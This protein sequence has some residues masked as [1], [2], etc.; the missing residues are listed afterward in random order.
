MSTKWNPPFDEAFDLLIDG[1]RVPAASG[2]T[3]SVRDPRTQEAFG[4]VAA[5]GPDD[6]DAAVAAAREGQTEWQSISNRK[7]GRILRDVAEL[8]RDHSDRLLELLLLENGKSRPHAEGEV[9]VAAKYFDYYAGI[10]DKIQG[11]QIP[12]GDEYVDFTVREPLGVI[13]QIVPWNL[14]VQLF[15][16]GSAVSLATGNAVV[17]KPAEQTP[18]TA[19]AIGELIH[20]A[21]VPAKAFNVVP[22]FGHEAG[23]ALTEHE[24]VDGLA[25]TG[26]VE[27]G[28]KVLQEAGKRLIPAHGELGGKSPNAVFP[29]AD[30]DHAVEQAAGAIFTA[31]AGQACSAGS[32]L[33]VHSDI[34]DEFVADVADVAESIAVGPDV[35][36]PDIS[37]II[38]ERQ[39]ENVMDYI[40]IGREE[41]G[42]PLVGG[43]GYQNGGY[44]VEPTIFADVDNG[45]RIAQE[46]IFGPVLVTIS[47]DDEAEAIR[48]ANDTNY[49]LAAGIFTSDI[50]RAHRY[51]REVDAGQIYINQYFAEDISTPF[52][53]YKQSGRGREKGLEAIHEYTQVKNVCAN[54]TY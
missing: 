45:T 17:A 5:G 43:E 16:R 23:A 35:D 24:G 14:P 49:G 51:A 32:R 54:I 19:L 25:F 44:Y 3:L 36:D 48:I 47:F 39:F 6:V 9:E 38:S 13:G 26:S 29:D 8:I 15:G 22:G 34:H 7:R 46:E 52:G 42:D 50:G 28:Q 1:E 4:R 10:T 27:T 18:I 12:L 33:L 41:V 31:L 53:G 40:E 30:W 20:E 21:G 11:E 2:E 37:P